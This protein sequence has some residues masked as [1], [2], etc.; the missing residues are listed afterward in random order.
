MS[1]SQ[2]SGQ[3]M[4]SV[5]EPA[6]VVGGHGDGLEDALDL[7]L[8]EAV[9]EQPLVRARLHEG[10][11]AR[12]RGH[13]LGADADQPARARFGGDRGAEQR[14]D[15]LRLDAADGRRLVLRVA[16]LDVHLGA[17]RALAVAHL[18]GDVLRQCF[19][20]E[21]ALAE[22]DLAD[23]LVD[24]LLEAAHVRALLVRAEVDE[25]VQ[26]GGEQLLGPVRADPD[27]L[28]DVGHT[29]AREGKGERRNPALD[30][31]QRQSHDT[32]RSSGRPN[33]TNGPRFRQG[34][35]TYPVLQSRDGTQDFP[36]APQGKPKICAERRTSRTDG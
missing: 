31:L 16:G 4:C 27:D 3:P 30:V 14:V 15:L 32:Q 24:D 35:T 20:A 36:E 22:H 17:A 23:R 6:L 21:R 13:A 29:H 1:V 26:A 10:L 11:R 5:A 28:L 33:W 9:G 34:Q 18:L 25:A 8:G 7:V 2:H 12:A 19:R